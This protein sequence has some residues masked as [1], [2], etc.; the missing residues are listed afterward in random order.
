[1][2]KLCL[3]IFAIILAI[4]VFSQSEK[5][6]VYLKNG[7]ILKGKYQYKEDKLYVESAGNLWVFDAS[8][9]ENLTS[10]KEKQENS[11]EKFTSESPVFYRVEMGLLVGNS[12]NSQ[13]APF[14]FTGSVNYAATEQF[15]AGLG[16]GTEFFKESYLPVFLNLE[17]KIRNS[18]TTPYFFLKGGYQVPLEDGGAVYYD[19]YPA[20]SSIWPGPIYDNETMNSKG[21]FLINPGI[22]LMRMFSPAFGMSVAFGYQF[23]RLHYTAENDY[24]LDIDYNRLTLKVGII[25]N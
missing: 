11:M 24:A 8:E 18:Y 3:F 20:W 17:Y 1:M 5:G 2:K 12:Q 22:G 6:Y 9:I 13:S 23:H 21:G 4:P 19:Y 15:S 16:F 10:K 25:F 7:T 14:S